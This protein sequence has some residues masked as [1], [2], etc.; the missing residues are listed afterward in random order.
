MVLNDDGTTI[1]IISKDTTNVAYIYRWIF[2]FGPLWTC[3]FVATITM[4]LVYKKVLL[5]EQEEEKSH[6]Q[7]VLSFSLHYF[8]DKRNHVRDSESGVAGAESEKA[9]GATASLGTASAAAAAAAATAGIKTLEEERKLHALRIRR[10]Y[11][12]EGFDLDVT[13]E[14]GDDENDDVD[15]QGIA[16]GARNNIRSSISSMMNNSGRR[17]SSSMSSWFNISS[18]IGGGGGDDPQH[19]FRLDA[20]EEIDDDVDEG[21]GGDGNR[22]SDN[23][24]SN[25]DYDDNENSRTADASSSGLVELGTAATASSGSSS[26]NT[27]HTQQS[28]KHHH[29]RHRRHHRGSF[30]LNPKMRRSQQ[31]FGQGLFYLGAFYM[32][33]LFATTNR[34]LQLVQGHTYY[35]LLVFHSFFDPLQVRNTDHFMI[36]FAFSWGLPIPSCSNSFPVPVPH[37]NYEFSNICRPKTLSFRRDS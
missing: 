4:I 31:V 33:H 9:S 22:S 36:H 7:H 26:R 13:D 28:R 30:Y 23:H 27:P 20:A 24:N 5:S 18:G 32:T 12:K 29:R 25:N 1:I 2:Y 21:D 35:P 3:I 8:D 19:P 15:A 16:R 10:S 6:Q 37:T 14:D 11:Q 17:E 34:L